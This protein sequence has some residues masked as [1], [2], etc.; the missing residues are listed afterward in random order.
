MCNFCSSPKD[1][2]CWNL[3]SAL[4]TKPC[5]LCRVVT[6]RE[7]ERIALKHCAISLP[8]HTG[9]VFKKSVLAGGREEEGYA[10]C[11]C[12]SFSNFSQ[13]SGSSPSLMPALHQPRPAMTSPAWQDR[14]ETL[15]QLMVAV[16]YQVK[17]FFGSC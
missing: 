8:D 17:I 1:Q 10:V 11:V 15:C 6:S 7:R 12:V 9:H 14:Q 13:A 5:V 16:S 3:A 2:R 4:F